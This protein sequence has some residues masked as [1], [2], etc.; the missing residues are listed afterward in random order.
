MKASDKALIGKLGIAGFISAADNWVV[1]PLL[2][3]IAAGFDVSLAQAG[4]I[5]T[6]YMIPYG[7]MQPVYGFWS[8][9]RGK[10]KVLQGIVGGLALGT[11][12][13]CLAQSLIV[14]CF[15]RFITGFFAAGIIAVSLALIG[16]TVAVDERQKG[17]GLFGGLVF[18]GQG[19]SA[20]CGGVLAKYVSWRVS[21][22][23]CAIMAVGT[24]FFLRK[25]PAGLSCPEGP[26]FLAEVRRVTLSP[27]G[28]V[29]FPLSFF[30]GF[31]LLGSYS[32]LG[33]FLH[34]GGGLD[35]LQ[36]GMIMM[37]F[38]LCCFLVGGKVGKLAQKIGYRKTI[39]AGGGFAFA[40]SLLLASFSFWQAGLCATIGLSLA[41]GF[42]QSTLA[43]LAFNVSSQSK[44][45]PSA[46]VGLGL[47]GGG[48]VGALFGGGMLSISS[49]TVL[50]L[51]FSGGDLLFIL[52]A[53]RF[54]QRNEAVRRGR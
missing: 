16:D 53:A 48:G 33:A 27:Q 1:S 23:L 17:V 3:A 41:Y 4:E 24:V 30:S 39:L 44:G 21:F 50:W 51:T 11:A 9:R 22:A 6:A 19:L 14:L 20:G 47:F 35:Y 10:A 54:L 46:L 52:T 26:S 49:Y 43:T 38:G 15:W 12:G 2:P 28:R 13:C 18:L 5:L 45:L 29:I 7:M 42:I 40:A 32:Y 37:F 31:L 36:V 8:D 34:A 25:L